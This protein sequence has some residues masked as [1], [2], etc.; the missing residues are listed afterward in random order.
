MV[1]LG[2]NISCSTQ[3]IEWNGTRIPWK[4]W[5]YFD[6]SILQD[7]VAADAHCMFID[8]TFHD[9]MDQLMDD[10]FFTAPI[11]ESLY[12]AISTQEVLNHQKHLNST[13]LGELRSVLDNFTGLFNGDLV[14]MGKLG[15]F[16]GPKVHLELLPNEQPTKQ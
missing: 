14:K 7:P 11:K 2:I 3:T 15:K 10:C 13:Q 16:K 5:T 4:P 6:D 8:S 1:Q 9:D 12:K